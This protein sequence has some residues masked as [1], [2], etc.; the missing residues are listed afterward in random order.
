MK[1][2]NDVNFWVYIMESDE[3]AERYGSEI[4]LKHPRFCEQEIR[5]KGMCVHSIFCSKDSVVKNRIH[6]SM[7]LQPP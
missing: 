7:S 1:L 3:V 4:T 5:L 6:L 2:K